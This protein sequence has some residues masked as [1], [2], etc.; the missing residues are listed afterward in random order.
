M[1]IGKKS[2]TQLGKTIDRSRDTV[3]RILRPREDNFSLLHITAERIFRNKKV[4]YLTIDDS[5][6]RKIYSTMMQ[7]ACQFF[8]SKIGRMVTS[9][10][11][12][13]AGLTDGRYII[14]IHSSFLYSKEV[15]PN[16]PELK[17][18]LPQDIILN[19][20]KAFAD[21][22]IIVVMDGAF[23]TV[24]FL[25]WACENGVK[26]TLR[27]H[28]NRIIT[29]NG[30]KQ[31]ISEI[32][33]L[34]P[35]GRHMARTIKA[36]WHGML[37]YITAE[38]RIDKHGEES[39]VYL[40]ST[41]KAKPSEYVKHYK[42]RWPIEK[43][44]RTSK[45]HLGLQDCYSTDLDTQLNHISSVLLSYAIIQLEMKK[46]KYDTPEDVIRS[47]R[48]DDFNFLKKRILALG[49]IFT[50]TYTTCA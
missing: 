17:E 25:K 3:K 11:L 21:K 26:A 6:L 14:P 35:K 23:A 10:K 22:T 5:I 24:N 45:Q 33:D 36:C 32:V 13:L 38:R 43:L 20:I 48:D 27:M 1:S 46:S 16:A 7:G 9:F 29:Y 8:D 39:I 44:I 4:I 37:L 40:V 31:R 2:F 12:L 50:E 47:F 42:C 28:S 34:E 15:C 49:E 18:K 30:V 19:T 41:Y